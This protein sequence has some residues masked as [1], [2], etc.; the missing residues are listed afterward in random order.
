MKRIFLVGCPRS[1]TSVVQSRLADH[2]DVA[3]APESLFFQGLFKHREWLEGGFSRYPLRW[4]TRAFLRSVQYRCGFAHPEAKRRLLRFLADIDVGEQLR[5][6]AP[7]AIRVRKLTGYFVRGL[8]EHA[9]RAG[10]RAWLEKTPSHV[11]HAAGIAQLVPGAL[12]VHLVRDPEDTAAS[13]RDAALRYP[14]LHWG[15][16][17]PTAEA[18]AGR[19]VA[20]ARASLGWLG[21]PDHTHVRFDDFV[22]DPAASLAAIDRFL[23]LDPAA[24]SGRPADGPATTVAREYEIWKADVSRDVALPASKFERVFSESD[25]AL[26]QRLVA[27]TWAEINKRI[28]SMHGGGT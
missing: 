3:T 7:Q 4:R 27:S 11:H 9:R 19:W 12:F 1:G 22:A 16:R 8:D 17:Y 6:D 15:T 5:L 10:A 28:P 14:H 18:C 24:R 25:R 13:L 20:S 2:P 23:C 26:V 21:R